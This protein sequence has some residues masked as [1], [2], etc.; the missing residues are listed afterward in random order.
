MVADS[1]VMTE[2]EYYDDI[3]ITLDID[4]LRQVIVAVGNNYVDDPEEWGELLKK[5]VG[6]LDEQ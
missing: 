2:R 1:L 6:V 5:L 3:E 4:E